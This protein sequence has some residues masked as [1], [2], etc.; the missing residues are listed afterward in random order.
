[1]Q[2]RVAHGH[3]HALRCAQKVKRQILRAHHPL[4]VSPGA[5]ALA[6]VAYDTPLAKPMRHRAASDMSAGS[7]VE[8][9]TRAGQAVD[10]ASACDD[11]PMKRGADAGEP[12]SPPECVAGKLTKRSDPLEWAGGIDLALASGR[13]WRTLMDRA[14][15]DIKRLQMISRARGYKKG[16]PQHIARALARKM[17]KS[18]EWERS[19]SAQGAPA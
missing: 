19:I 16:W 18:P 14:G 8:L 9:D 6:V 10:C 13:E 11:C 2:L 7:D 5:T 15:G 1:M 4:A 17:S 12:I 3:A